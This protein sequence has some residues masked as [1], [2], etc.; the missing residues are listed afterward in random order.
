MLPSCFL[1]KLYRF[2]LL[3]TTYGQHLT[4]ILLNLHE[5]EQFFI[6]LFLMYVGMCVCINELLVSF[7]L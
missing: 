6:D 2:I 5:V 7:D 3:S 1:K 4:H